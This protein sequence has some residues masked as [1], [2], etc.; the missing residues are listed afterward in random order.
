MQIGRVTSISMSAHELLLRQRGFFFS[1]SPVPLCN[2][3]FNLTMTAGS[4]S[5]WWCNSTGKPIVI[6]TLILKTT[7]RACMRVVIGT[8]F[9]MSHKIAPTVIDDASTPMSVTD[10]WSPANAQLWLKSS[11]VICLTVACSLIG[12]TRM[13]SL[14]H[15]TP[16]SIRPAMQKPDVA[17]LYTS[18]TDMRNGLSIDRSGIRNLSENGLAEITKKKNHSLARHV[19]VRI[20]I[21]FT[22]D[23]DQCG[24]VV[25]GD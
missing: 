20:E 9:C 12:H 4:M 10:T 8:T 1:T 24:S 7:M 5:D 17:P 18:V 2:C 11:M 22:D 14:G 19:T 25:P 23:I 3:D 21:E 13:R 16:V 6:G 15:N